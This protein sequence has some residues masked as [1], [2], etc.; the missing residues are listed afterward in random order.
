MLDERSEFGRRRKPL[1]KEGV[2][3]ILRRMEDA[4]WRPNGWGKSGGLASHFFNR[5]GA[6]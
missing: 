6:H 5:A 1:V 4:A 2:P 3:A